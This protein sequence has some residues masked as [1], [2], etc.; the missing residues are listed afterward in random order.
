MTG[1]TFPEFTVAEILEA[2]EGILLR[3]EAGKS[4]KGV[5]TDSRN[6]IPGNLFVALRGPVFDGHD[7]LDQAR[8]RGAGA[9]LVHRDDGQGR[10]G[11]PLI[12]V[13]DTLTAL[14]DLA[15][16][17]RKRFALPVLAITGSAGKTTTK[18]MAALILAERKNVLKTAGNF[19]NL[20][21]LPLTLFRLE[22]CHEAAILE[23]GTNRPGE[24]ARL[25]QI[26]DPDIALVT[27]V[28]PAHLEGF[29][30]IHGVAEEKGDL[31][32]Y[33]RK[34]GIA[35]VNLEDEYVRRFDHNQTDQD[36]GH[37][38]GDENAP[39][40]FLQV[41]RFSGQ[42]VGQKKN[43]SDFHEF[44]HLEGN[45]SEAQ[46]AGSATYPDPH[47][48]D[49]DQQQQNSRQDHTGI[50]QFPQLFVGNSL[51]KSHD[52]QTQ[53][54]EDDLFFQKIL[55][56]LESLHGQDGTGAIDHDRSYGHEDQGNDHE[57]HI[58]AL[59]CGLEFKHPPAPRPF[60][61]K[62]AP[63]PCNP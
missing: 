53:Q 63:D 60:S 37:P 43:N 14:G 52:P 10:N 7:Y 11:L 21:G 13:R 57:N 45:R 16:A 48:G 51:Q 41:L 9:L 32:R 1:A 58:R 24:I 17:W 5:T 46:P 44:R 39:G 12:L 29:G 49:E 38:H 42:K 28:G 31:F 25:T 36:K 26:S 55:R 2:T 22:G 34:G 8:E 18:E 4:L 47:M 54:N 61:E 59:G 27:N 19:N 3:G 20:I 6:I 40:P 35:V 15:S 62:N 56:V 50:G 30:S 33:M 23:L